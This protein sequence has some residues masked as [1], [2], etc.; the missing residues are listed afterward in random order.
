MFQY[1]AISF[2]DV[3]VIVKLPRD[4]QIKCEIQQG[5]DVLANP[6]GKWLVIHTLAKFLFEIIKN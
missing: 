2:C 3:S 5:L 4:R 1:L 6:N